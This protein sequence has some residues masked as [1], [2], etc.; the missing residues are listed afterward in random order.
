MIKVSLDVGFGDIK[1]SVSDNGNIIEK[2]KETISYV[3]LPSEDKLGMKY[4][5]RDY[6]IVR[7]ENKV[8]R[9][10]ESALIDSDKKVIDVVDYK[11]MKLAAPL[12]A[13]KY[14]RKY[15]RADK[16]LISLS[17]A[18]ASKI[19]EFEENLNSVLG[20]K[21]LGKIR[22]VP[23]S[24]MAKVALDNIGMDIN[25]PAPITYQN[26]MLIDIGYS[27]LDNC[28]VINGRTTPTDREGLEGEGVIKLGR[29]VI[30][31]IQ[32]TMGV[33]RPLSEARKIIYDKGFY[34]RGK[35]FDCSKIVDDG[36]KGY[37]NELYKVI[38]DRYGKK[39]DMLP[40][41]ILVG[42]GAE[43]IKS[44]LDFFNNLYDKNFALI[45]ASDAEYY[46]SIG[47]LF[48]PD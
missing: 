29:H 37:L 38:E 22:V 17:L 19:T 43:L 6:D 44:H 31:Q 4:D 20:E 18:F 41:M 39:L 3:E 48:L 36:I 30:S 33:T 47:A 27:T 25:N 21:Y 16:I 46:N 23:Q 34:S 14:L 42:G 7:H 5:D 32:S 2:Y 24:A 10:G 8:Y 28:I 13:K 9:I 35:F 26:Y 15:P 12:V 45:P 11:S 40:N 1:C